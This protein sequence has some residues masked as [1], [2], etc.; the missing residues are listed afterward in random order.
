MHKGAN[1]ITRSAGN[2]FHSEGFTQRALTSISSEQL[3]PYNNKGCQGEIY[4]RAKGCNSTPEVHASHNSS[5]TKRWVRNEFKNCFFQGAK[6]ACCNG[7]IKK[8]DFH[9][10]SPSCGT[11]QPAGSKKNNIRQ[12]LWHHGVGS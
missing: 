4:L 8:S 6:P 3:A 2:V 10:L 12:L 7:C 11:R 9:V 5:H 1:Y